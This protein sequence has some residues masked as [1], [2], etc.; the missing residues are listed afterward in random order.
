MSPMEER[1]R[2]ALGVILTSSHFFS[3]KA[4]AV[5]VTE[6]EIQNQGKIRRMVLRV[7]QFHV[8]AND[9]GG[10]GTKPRHQESVS[11]SIPSITVKPGCHGN[12]G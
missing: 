9:L 10:M 11:Q 7:S 5:S 12:W 1:L 2:V 3:F 8:Y 4:G 6:V